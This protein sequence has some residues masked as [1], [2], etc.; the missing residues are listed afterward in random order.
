MDCVAAS[1]V[2]A[3]DPKPSIE[4]RGNAERPLIRE[5]N[6][7]KTA[8]MYEGVASPTQG[9]FAARD[10]SHARRMGAGFGLV[11]RNNKQ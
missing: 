9:Q 6:N 5:L 3:R 10:D 8:E 4:R 7:A 11:Q 1:V 2:V